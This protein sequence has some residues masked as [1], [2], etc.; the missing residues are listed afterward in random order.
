MLPSHIAD[1]A[2]SFLCDNRLAALACEAGEVISS[3]D[4]IDLAAEARALHMTVT[5]HCRGLDY[6]ESHRKLWIKAHEFYE[7][8]CEIWG[9]VVP[10]DELIASHRRLLEHLR[11]VSADRMEFYSDVD[12][13]AYRRRKETGRN[14][15]TEVTRA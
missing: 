5:L 13:T 12:R 6:I 8:A 9:H 10:P 11:D 1:F 15:K 7:A 14:I 4:I 2:R 3:E